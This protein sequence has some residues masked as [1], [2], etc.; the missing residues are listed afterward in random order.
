MERL[1]KLRDKFQTRVVIKGLRLDKDNPY[2]KQAF[3]RFSRIFDLIPF[4]TVDI[5]A[6]IIIA[7]SKRI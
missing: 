5:F 4:C 1:E 2:E 3:F 7:E 6:V